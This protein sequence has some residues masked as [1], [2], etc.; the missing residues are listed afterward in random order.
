MIDELNGLAAAECIPDLT[1]LLDL[2][3][4]AGFRRTAER[5][6]TRGL[7]DRFEE[8]K[9]D[10]HRRV[11]EAFL[12]IAAA[13]PERVRVVDADRAPELVHAEIGKIVHEAL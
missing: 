11:R 10:F 2:S 5:E 4:E 12:K 8:E 7:H 13:E 9:L 1:I 6:E 3:P